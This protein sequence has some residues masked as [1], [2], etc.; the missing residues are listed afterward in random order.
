VLGGTGTGFWSQRGGPK[1][2]ADTR[3]LGR[4]DGAEGGD[5]FG[6]GHVDGQGV[7]HR[8]EALSDEEGWR[9][10]AELI[11]YREFGRLPNERWPLPAEEV[12]DGWRAWYAWRKLP[13]R[14]PAALLMT[15]PL[16]V[17]WL[18]VRVLGVTGPGAGSEGQRKKLCVHFVGAEVELNFLPLWV[19]PC[20]CNMVYRAR[21]SDDRCRFSEVALLLP[22]HDVQMV[23]FGQTADVKP[24]RAFGYR[25]PDALGGA[26]IE[27]RLAGGPWTAVAGRERPDAVVGCNAG[28]GAYAGW[29]PLLAAAA[30]RGLPVAVTEYSEAEAGGGGGGG[31]VNPFHRPGQRWLSGGSRAPNVVNGFVVVR[32][33]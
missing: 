6:G 7:L 25:A 9:L 3:Y 13:L 21:V 4:E 12:L 31:A 10:P 18:L 16:T 23:V 28:L 5:G 11:P 24:G 22:H 14:S 20:T 15:Y 30:A 2:H 1:P 26:T 8:G 19:V 27:I 17:Y 33:N 29:G 32:G